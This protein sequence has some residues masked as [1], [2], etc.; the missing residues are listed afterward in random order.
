MRQLTR[1]GGLIGLSLLLAACPRPLRPPP[2]SAD[3][4]AAC[5]A[6]RRPERGA[7]VYE[8]SSQSSQL[9]IY[10]FRGGKFSK[11]GHNHVMTSQNLT[12]RVWVHPELRALGLRAVVPG[13]AAG[14]RRRG[15]AARGRR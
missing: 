12:G 6:A 11:L 3:A 5:S 2:P 14:R 4:A 7:T 9:A 8:V 10:V 1:V 15:S 13:Y